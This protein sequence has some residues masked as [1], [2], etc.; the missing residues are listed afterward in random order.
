M[1]NFGI[2]VD[3][4][5]VLCFLYIV[6]LYSSEVDKVNNRKGHILSGTLI[7]NNSFFIFYWNSVSTRWSWWPRSRQSLLWLS[8]MISAHAGNVTLWD[9]GKLVWAGCW[10]ISLRSF[11]DMM[12]RS[13]HLVL[14]GSEAL[15]ALS[16]GIA[17]LARD[18]GFVEAP[19]ALSSFPGP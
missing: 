19:S 17:K 5:W 12:L 4:P 2:Y 6:C 11:W 16:S 8:R 15:S 14:P 3:F 13:Q 9:K 7:L 1:L 10:R 18:V